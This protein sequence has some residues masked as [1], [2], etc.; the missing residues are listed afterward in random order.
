M[1]IDGTNIS[2]VRGDS[3]AIR[4]RM[5]DSAGVVIPFIDGDIV[6]LT[7]KEHARMISFGFQKVVTEFSDNYAVISIEPSDT[8][9]LDFKTYAY[10]VELRTTSGMVK[11]LI[12]SSNFEISEEITYA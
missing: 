4:V 1:I 12:R 3:E 11:T 9:D 2:M 7:V 10:D 8:E 6:R 5:V